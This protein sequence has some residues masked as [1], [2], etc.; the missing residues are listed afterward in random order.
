MARAHLAALEERE[1]RRKR[2]GQSRREEGRKLDE[3]RKREKTHATRFW[4]AASVSFHPRVLSPQSG[5]Y[6]KTKVK[7]N[8]SAYKVMRR[9]K[10]G[11]LRGEMDEQR[12]GA[13]RGSA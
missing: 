1:K 13:Q 6:K 5:F 7:N 10:E 2:R 8:A 9:R 3:G 4:R 11:M 12:R